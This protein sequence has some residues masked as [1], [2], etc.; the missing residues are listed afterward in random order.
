LGQ[1][2]IFHVQAHR[3]TSDTLFQ[4]QRNVSACFTSKILKFVSA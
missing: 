4:F 3:L 1:V 2:F